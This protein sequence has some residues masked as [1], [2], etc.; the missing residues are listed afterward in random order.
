[1]IK[2]A[3][4]YLNLGITPP[5]FNETHIVLIPKV[6]GPKQVQEYQPISLCNV[7]D[8]LASK[9]VANRLKVVLP[10]LVLRTSVHL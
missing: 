6:K 9:T 4:D 8:K 1:M 2:T 5:K 10:N 3:L 7:A